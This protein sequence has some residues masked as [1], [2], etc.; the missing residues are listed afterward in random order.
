MTTPLQTYADRFA[1]LNTDRS[2]PWEAATRGQAPHKPFLLLSVLDRFA[3]GAITS[4][5]IELT[6]DLGELFDIYWSLVKPRGRARGNVATPFFH[7]SNEG[8][9]HLQ[10]REGR[11]EY[12]SHVRRIHAI[13]ELQETVHGARLDEALYELLHVEEHRQT[14]RRV[15]LETYFAP[16]LQPRLLA[17]GFRNVKASRYGEELLQ[18]AKGELKEEPRVY[19]EDVDEAEEQAVRDQ[20]FRR[21]IVRA[22]AHRCALCGLRIRTADGHSA[23]V[24][25]H[26]VPWSESQDDDPRNGLALCHLCHWT[27]DEGL[28]TVGEGYEIRTSPQ[29]AANEN[30]PGHLPTLDR[31]P[32]IG[33][34]DRELWPFAES[35]RWHRKEVYRRR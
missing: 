10:P 1:N 12:L 6:P 9:W 28:L 17:Q 14:L 11:E 18:R 3:E 30:L 25:A 20:G 26:I 35:L 2:H 5:L 16:E 15:L 22:Y 32:F 24:A 27:F 21:A 8:F 7:L 33:P 29:L 34:G 13:S 31:R 4:N 23:I 19:V